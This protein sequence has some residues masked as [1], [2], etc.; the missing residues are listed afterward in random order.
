MLIKLMR[1]KGALASMAAASMALGRPSAAEDIA[2]RVHSLARTSE[3][4]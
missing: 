4:N 1:D 2:G 3:R